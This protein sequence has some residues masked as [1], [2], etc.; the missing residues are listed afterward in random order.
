MLPRNFAHLFKETEGSLK[1]KVALVVDNLRPIA[2]ETP[3]YCHIFD[4]NLT[5]FGLLYV[6]SPEFLPSSL[7]TELDKQCLEEMTDAKADVIDHKLFW[8]RSRYFSAAHALNHSLH[9]LL[10]NWAEVLD[11]C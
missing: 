8:N 6:G 1:R 7:F 2:V 10:G 11:L 4:Q 9:V 5:D 3:Q